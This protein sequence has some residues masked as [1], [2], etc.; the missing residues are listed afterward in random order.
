[1]YDW[2]CRLG[3]SIPKL[4]HETVSSYAQTSSAPLVNSQQMML[5]A[6]FNAATVFAPSSKFYVSMRS[7]ATT[8][9]IPS[10]TDWMDK[11]GAQG[12]IL[13]IVPKCSLDWEQV[14]EKT[15]TKKKYSEPTD[16]QV[17]EQGHGGH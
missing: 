3:L 1:M 4:A 11:E 5:S 13:Q 14:E 12:L 9:A 7:D 6:I 8:G 10:S 2:L 17:V 16:T 15:T